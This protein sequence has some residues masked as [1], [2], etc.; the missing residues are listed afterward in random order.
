MDHEGDTMQQ[1]KVSTFFQYAG[2]LLK[3]YSESQK[4]Q[5]DIY[6][7]AEIKQTKTDEKKFVIQVIGKSVFIE[8]TPQ[9]IVV[10]DRMLEGF[11]K[12]DIRTIIYLACEQ[13]RKPKYKIVVQE[14][15][16]KFNRILFKLKVK[17]DEDS[18]EKTANQ[19][20]LDK[21]LINGLSQ[22]D[23]KNVSYIAGYEHSQSEKE[24][25]QAV[26]QEACELL[27]IL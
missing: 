27:N 9:E 1:K 19:I 16:E 25:M 13:I 24:T 20:L 6:R 23:I 22:E 26:R 11:S 15:C 10:D 7:I 3:I 17:N 5:S 12:K 18:I 4:P 2:W 14:F 8:C 21:S